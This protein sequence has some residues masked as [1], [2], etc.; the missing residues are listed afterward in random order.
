[1]IKVLFLN[2]DFMEY[3]KAI[4]NSLSNHGLS[5]TSYN[6]S[7]NPNFFHRL[8]RLFTGKK[9]MLIA[10]DFAQKN[11]IKQFKEHN[12]DV[13]FMTA[14]H[15]MKVDTLKRL[16][17]INPNTLFVWYSWDYEEL[18]DDFVN[19]IKCFDIVYN[20]EKRQ[21]RKYNIG[22]KPLFYCKPYDNT[23]KTVDLGFVGTYHSNRHE[24]IYKILDTYPNISKEIYIL[25]HDERTTIS[26]I[27]DALLFRKL[28]LEEYCHTKGLSYDETMQITQRSKCILDFPY[29]GQ[30]GLTIRTIEALGAK[31]KL[32][33]TNKNIVDYD[34]YN[35]H[36]IYVIDPK[37]MELPPEE[38]ILGDYEAVQNDIYTSYSL[39]SWIEW[40]ISIF[41]SNIQ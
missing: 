30:E 31:C 35:D 23:P 3:D 27:I 29:T 38:F 39:D 18:V 7:P 41:S 28:P 10:A 13:V 34:F 4:A 14:G 16:K 19:K 40:L 20:F 33:T 15:R 5:V 9:A 32:I 11:L 6:Y 24:Y 26:K 37:K 12:Y 25:K 17:Q 21:A 22:F 8:L 36:N 1:M 2:L